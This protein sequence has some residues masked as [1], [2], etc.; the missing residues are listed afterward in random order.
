MKEKPELI[1]EEPSVPKRKREDFRPMLITMALFFSAFLSPG[2]SR[3][4]SLCIPP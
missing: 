3:R 2:E 1:E 4:L